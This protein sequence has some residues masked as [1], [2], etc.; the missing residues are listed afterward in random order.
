M[1]VNLTDVLLRATEPPAAGTLTLWDT[2]LRHFGVR[3]SSGGAKT[4]ILLLGSG[5]R[6]AIGRFEPKVF[7]LGQAR[8]KARQILAENVLGRY[9]PHSICF[10]DAKTQW[11]A[12]CEGEVRPKTL[13]D[14]TRLINRH[15]KFGPKQAGDITPHNVYQKLDAIAEKEERAYAGVVIKTFFK[16]CEARHYIDRSPAS[17]IPGRKVKKR[18]RIL[19]DSELKSIWWACVRGHNVLPVAFARIVQS[20]ILTGLRRG[21]CA[22]TKGEYVA[23]DLL[24]L[25][26]EITK[27]GFEHVLP[28]GPMSKSFMIASKG[29]IFLG[30]KRGSAFNGW[31]KAKKSLDELCEVKDWTLHD[32]RRTFR[33]I[34]SK[35][36]TP[37]HIAEML[38]NHVSARGQLETTYDRYAYLDEKREAILHYEEHIKTV[39]GL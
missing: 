23:D 11:L 27:N 2:N 10:D 26:P 9:H 22:Q 18:S 24:I 28:L 30:R 25:P 6:H 20:L 7:G 15:F 32:T 5:N 17:S 35:I 8:E 29:F 21:E 12:T 33:T 39:L 14:Y 4:F 38:L 31:S 3:I 36:K 34:H 1:H 37:P 13:Y 19:S 16:W